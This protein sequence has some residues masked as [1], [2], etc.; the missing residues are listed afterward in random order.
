MKSNLNETKTTN[1]V[2]NKVKLAEK[3]KS[4]K[5]LDQSPPRKYRHPS[6]SP[7]RYRRRKQSPSPNRTRSRSAPVVS[8]TRV[9]ITDRSDS[10]PL[11]D[12]SRK[13]SVIPA[14]SVTKTVKKDTAD[15]D[16]NGN[17]SDNLSDTDKEDDVK[18][19][20]GDPRYPWRRSR[21]DITRRADLFKEEM[22]KKLKQREKE[23]QAK[24]LSTQ[25][26]N[27]LVEQVKQ[28]NSLGTA[29]N[30]QHQP[31]CEKQ[32]QSQLT[33]VTH[34]LEIPVTVHTHVTHHQPFSIQVPIT[35]DI[36]FISSAEK[37]T[38]SHVKTKS[39]SPTPVHTITMAP[40]VA[41]LPV[42]AVKEIVY[43][44]NRRLEALVA[45]QPELTKPLTP[46]EL[47][48]S[49]LRKEITSPPS[50]ASVEETEQNQALNFSIVEPKISSLVDCESSQKIEQQ[51]L[52]QKIYD[53][54]SP[55]ASPPFERKHFNFGHSGEIS[56]NSAK[57]KVTFAEKLEQY[58]EIEPRDKESSQ[59][60]LAGVD[61]GPRFE[62]GVQYSYNVPTRQF[63]ISVSESQTET[64][65][66]PVR[67]SV[68]TNQPSRQ[69]Y[70]FNISTSGIE[71]HTQ[72][73]TNT[74]SPVSL[75]YSYPPSYADAMY[76]SSQGVKAAENI[77]NPG[78]N[79]QAG[80]V[81]PS[82]QLRSSVLLPSQ[83]IQTGLLSP[84]NPTQHQTPLLSP[85]Q[86][87][88][89]PLLS[90][91]QQVM[92]LA[93]NQQGY[94]QQVRPGSPTVGQFVSSSSGHSPYAAGQHEIQLRSFRNLETRFSEG[95]NIVP[96]DLPTHTQG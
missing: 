75:Q 47:G 93:S 90:P 85:N 70:H 5:F 84:Q 61:I 78:S 91:N 77:P 72:P 80:L 87:P 13:L 28:V 35:Q 88:H 86:K 51:P 56:P 71:V 49:F 40:E 41:D 33:Q 92:L 65:Q 11:E 76:A 68:P 66:A 46:Q 48:I 3:G 27:V 44:L 57:K 4:V 23:L 89:S 17:I 36:D 15:S 30:V 29:I 24:S 8:Y 74:N 26:D 16:T 21:A 20:T 52:Y 94:L 7:V 6:P 79:I 12:S 95:G 60:V 96:P 42:P 25:S 19:A 82:Q 34:T 58:H 9:R 45:R 67:L 43:D 69:A 10:K 39:P 32:L 38:P 62:P 14:E 73:L 59:T 64:P 37:D 55:L 50:R 31:K 81:S 22:E 18:K 54:S 2:K 63:E 83:R 1:N 53:I